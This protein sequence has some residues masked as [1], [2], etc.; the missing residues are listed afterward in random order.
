MADERQGNYTN[1]ASSAFQGAGTGAA[2]GSVVPVIGTAIGAAAGFVIG[3]V[4]G[5]LRAG[6]ERRAFR[7]EQ[8]RRRRVERRLH[9]LASPENFLANMNRLRAGYREEVASGAG[10]QMQQGVR[11]LVAR[12]GLTGTGIG[13]TMLAQAQQAPEIEALRRAFGGA[14][15]LT[16]NQLQ[17]E[18]FNAS[19]GPYQEYL[20]P[21]LDPTTAQSIRNTAALFGQ[22]RDPNKD[23][24]GRPRSGITTGP[25]QQSL[26]PNSST[27]PPTTQP[28]DYNSLFQYSGGF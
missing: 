6:K 9:Y 24:W 28:I 8:A 5:S 22:M 12:R 13:D 20:P 21:G 3:G 17:A 16:Q 19:L 14:Q 18:Q 7:R 26:F 25:T 27:A 15:E 2:V 23:F 1:V 4:M 10:P 11:S